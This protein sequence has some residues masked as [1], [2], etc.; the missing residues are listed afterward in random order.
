MPNSYDQ[1][2]TEMAWYSYNGK[3]VNTGLVR[4]SGGKRD[5]GG[6]QQ[7][8]KPNPLTVTGVSNTSYRYFNTFGDWTTRYSDGS[9][10][11][12]HVP[13]SQKYGAGLET[14]TPT[15]N[16]VALA[17]LRANS[18]LASGNV[19]T[20][21]MVGEG[22]ET[23]RYIAARMFL[24]YRGLKM[25]SRGQFGEAAR[26]FGSELSQNAGKR[27]NRLRSQ[28]KGGSGLAANAW[29][30]YQFAIRPLVGDVYGAI[31][32]YHT[33]R[34]VGSAVK[35]SAT[36]KNGAKGT[37]Y[38]AGI[39]ATVRSKELRTLQQLGITNPLLAAWELV[40]LSFVI[41]WFVPIG[42]YLQYMDS[43]LGLENVQRWNSTKVMS[44]YY[45]LDPKR[46][47]EWVREVYQRNTTFWEIPSIAVGTNLNVGQLTTAAA[48]LQRFKR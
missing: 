23:V 25:I 44:R 47:T 22:R 24:L 28:Y 31:A 2:G 32:E 41:D 14:S 8:P 45:A 10:Y 42:S 13:A 1:A 36:V 4:V 27:L 37:V 39:L 9:V 15:P 6:S 5:W 16:G 20:L 12:Q 46:S 43:T 35:V 18:R 40:P 29:L 38:R 19:N 3:R 17:Q 11:V 48:L 33:K 21:V 7:R 26:V 34:Q 30:E